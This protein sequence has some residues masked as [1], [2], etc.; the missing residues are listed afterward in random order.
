MPKTLIRPHYQNLLTEISNIYTD[1]KLQARN[2]LK[3]ILTKAYWEIG[4]RIVTVEQNNELRARYGG[5]LLK[6]LS[7]DLTEKHGSGFSSRNLSYMRRFYIINPILQPAAELDWTKQC[8]LLSINDEHKR[9]K[10]NDLTISQN[11]S[12]ARL[13]EA[14]KNEN[15]ISTEG[16]RKVQSQILQASRGPL[17]IYSASPG[18]SGYVYVDV[19]FSITR[20]IQSWVA[21]QKGEAISSLK[22]GSGFQ[23]SKVRATP[24]DFYTYK[25][26]CDRV[27][28][29]DTIKLHIDLGFD[30]FISEVVRLRGINTPEIETK[31]GQRAKRFVTRVLEG[32]DD[33][34]VKTHREDKFGRTLADIWIDDEYLNQRLLDEGLAVL[35]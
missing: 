17:Y 7:K 25:A 11:W 24:K 12:R 14:L 28:D 29:G 6:R 18:E 33:M 1:S 2:E 16:S 22:S 19:G 35:F 26:Y 5:G 13:I 3:K 8:V 23:L 9:M 10:Y 4:K 34:I 15:L 20:Q 27:I 30:T 21:I 32:A 31:E